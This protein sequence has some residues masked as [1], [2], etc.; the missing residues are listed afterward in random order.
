MP[1]A[2]AAWKAIGELYHAWVTGLILTTV[3]RRSAA[4]AAALVFRTLSVHDRR[5]RPHVDQRPGVD[6]AAIVWRIGR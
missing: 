4:D 6:S 5:G 1:R 2:V 3:T